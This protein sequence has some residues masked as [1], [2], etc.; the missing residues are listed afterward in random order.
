MNYEQ[1]CYSWLHGGDYKGAASDG[2]GVA[3]T[4]SRDPAFIKSAVDLM[5]NRQASPSGEVTEY[6]EYSE[7]F[8]RF[9]YLGVRRLPVLPQM[10]GGDNNRLMH[11]YVPAGEETVFSGPAYTDYLKEVPAPEQR[12]VVNQAEFYEK[13]YDYQA[14]LK[15]YGLHQEQGEEA[16]HR[17][18]VL[19]SLL[20]LSFYSD[21][22]KQLVFPVEDR[23]PYETAREVT[24]LLH[25]LVPETVFGK[26]EGE[27]LHRLGYVAAG[28]IQGYHL[29]FIQETPDPSGLKQ[30]VYRFNKNY[31]ARTAISR[32]EMDRKVDGAADLFLALAK[33]AQ[34]SP[35]ESAA[36]LREILS[37]AK[38]SVDNIEELN[39]A[40]RSDYIPYKLYGGMSREIYVC[41]TLEGLQELDTDDREEL[42][43]GISR[44]CSC[45]PKTAASVYLTAGSELIRLL[46]DADVDEKTAA[47][48]LEKYEETGRFSKIA[49][50]P[51]IEEK[52]AVHLV[53]ERLKA[54]FLPETPDMEMK[55]ET[56]PECPDDGYEEQTENH[57]VEQTEDISVKDHSDTAARMAALSSDKKNRSFLL[58]FFRK[59][60]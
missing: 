23:N 49:V 13:S 26:T 58:N 11:L 42:L 45:N 28:G 40:Y 50:E 21:E 6:Y 7:S 44:Y 20:Y 2:W 54:F 17:F 39:Q 52:T 9:I 56:L 55:T 19:L 47:R 22:W 57:T 32:E 12:G 15:K 41:S 60:S 3:A 53:M 4:S 36:M 1:I 51:T 18:A 25:R 31:D 5:T 59:K 38:E 29:N 14:L 24:W 16:V 35:K 30:H 33:A 27:M 8:R 43:N 48:I 37:T 46:A 10:G 34:N